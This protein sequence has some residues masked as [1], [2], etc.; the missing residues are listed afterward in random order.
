MT[1][2]K[3]LIFYV[4]W[5]PLIN[6]L[7]DEKR[8]QFYDIILNPENRDREIFDPHLK[9]IVDFVLLKI[10]DNESKYNEVIE[11]RKIAGAR[12]GKQKLA[13]A[14]NSK[15]VQTNVA[16]NVNGNDNVNVKKKEDK[17]LFDDLPKEIRLPDWL[18]KTQWEGYLEMRKATKEPMTNLSKT[19]LLGK[20]EKMKSKGVDVMQA[21]EDAIINNWKSVYEPKETKPKDQPLEE[22]ELWKTSE[23]IRVRK[24]AEKASLQSRSTRNGI[25][26]SS[27]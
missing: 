27:N 12:G 23:R 25:T 4:E 18:P 9:S 24:E 2:K 6:S 3:S 8:L 17:K 22:S 19:L 11:K 5:L 1:Q 14:T 7:P 10:N 21:L 13:N 16:D 20:L 26:P 15:Q